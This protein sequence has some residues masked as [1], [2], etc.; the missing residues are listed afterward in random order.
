V[1]SQNERPRIAVFAGPT[2]TILNGPPLI[3]SNL[4]RRQRG[5]PL[6]T[7]EWGQPLRFDVLRPQRLAKP[8]TVYI[9]QFSAHPLERDAANLYG[10][11]DGYLDAEGELHAE[12]TSVDDRPVYEVVLSPEDGLLPLPY[13][14]LQRDGCP[15]DDDCA[16]PGA[17]ADMCRQ[18]FYPDASRI[19]EEI[20]RLGIDEFGAANLLGSQSDFDFF[21]AV[22]SGGYTQGRT[23]GHGDDPSLG[24]IKPEVLDRDFFPYRPGHL[25]SDPPRPL[26]ARLTNEVQAAMGSGRYA[27]GLWLEGS[28]SIEET[29]Y[30]L[31][32]MI[33]TSEPIV[34]CASSDWPHGCLTSGGDRNLVQAVRFIRSRIW[35]DTDGRDRIG[36]VLIE[37]GRAITARDVQKADARPGGF[38]ATGGHGGIVAS[39]GD[40]GEPV[41]TS[42]PV[43]R[44]TH[45][46]EVRLSTLRDKVRGVR[47]R[48]K[49][50]E[51]V[52]V[53][54]KD[55]AGLVEDSIPHVSIFKHARFLT[56][57]A[58]GDASSEV[59]ILARIKRNLEE[60]PLAGIVAEANAPYGSTAP[61]V[62]AAL[63]RATFSGMP[64]VRVGR[65]NP[66]GWVPKER[67]KFGIAGANL[68]ATKARLLLMACL[69]K[70]GALSPAVDPD[71]PTAEE[72]GEIQRVLAAYQE[73]FDTH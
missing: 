29:L 3:T 53:P 11:P 62:D 52:D 49:G 43:W 45:N 32:L 69:L 10:P 41:L 5:L 19:F 21:R 70:F 31:N 71:R 33:D 12:R 24:D 26:L 28:P 42:I 15:W 39:L 60:F 66:E 9:E 17:P 64:V 7:D 23:A 48:G 35:A 46:S 38:I 20:D 8:V 25:R 44:H 34:G 16:R 37:A 14:A 6:L 63:R 55:G 67:V 13:V 4:A 50:I 61:S 72:I 54:I 59:E 18:P 58:K 30:W 57:G 73:V 1:N 40:P 68:T 2:A 51:L 65:G 36:A 56:T 47:K 22:P 27:A